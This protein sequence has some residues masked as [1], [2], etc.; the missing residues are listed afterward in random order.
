MTRKESDMTDPH[1]P[2]IDAPAPLWRRLHR[3]L[4]SNGM[5]PARQRASADPERITALGYEAA[6]A[7]AP[8]TA[9]TTEPAPGLPPRAD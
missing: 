5:R 9:G 6:Y 3:L 1:I 4:R 8:S 2:V 7:P